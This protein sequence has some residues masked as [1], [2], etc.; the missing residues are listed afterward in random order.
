MTKDQ[1]PFLSPKI[2]QQT[3]EIWFEIATEPAVKAL[4]ALVACISIAYMVTHTDSYIGLV[5]AAIV[6]FIAVVIGTYTAPPLCQLARANEVTLR[7]HVLYSLCQVYQV[8]GA[9]CHIFKNPWQAI[10][11]PTQA[12]W[13]WT[14][15]QPDGGISPLVTQ[16]RPS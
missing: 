13:A 1:Q 14:Y 10:S 11:P 16:Q 8:P 3:M 5:G 9:P 15:S 6:G 2:Y 4:V 7:H 12:T